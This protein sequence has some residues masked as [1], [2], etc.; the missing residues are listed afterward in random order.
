[1]GERISMRLLELMRLDGTKTNKGYADCLDAAEETIRAYVYNFT[2]RGWIEVDRS[3]QRN[4][5]VLRE[6]DLS[7]K[8]VRTE[9]LEEMLPVL[10]DDFKDATTIT[11]RTSVSNLILKI[12]K[13]M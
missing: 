9:T 3:G 8:A 7:K 10:L 2:K 13:N 6:S 4:I 11:E 1:M 12:I 5:T